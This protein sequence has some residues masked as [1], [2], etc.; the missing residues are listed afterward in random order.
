MYINYITHCAKYNLYI[1]LKHKTCYKIISN[2][3]GMRLCNDVKQ[4]YQFSK[5][6]FLET[7]SLGTPMMNFEFLLY[8]IYFLT[9][10]FSVIYKIKFLC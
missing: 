3:E 10:L 1:L 5:Y 9:R 8:S 2:Y 7:I 6:Y 4:L